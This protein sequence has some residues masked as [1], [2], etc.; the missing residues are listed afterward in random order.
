M[1]IPRHKHPAVPYVA[2]FAVFLLCLL[3]AGRT[4]IPQPWESVAWVG[5]VAVTI[6]L[7][8]RQL[9]AG[10]RLSSGVMSL[11]VGVGV[12][13][14]WVAPD[15][16][17][18]GWRESWVFQNSITGHVKISIAPAELSSPLVLWLRVVRAVVLVPILEELFWRGWLPRWIQDTKFERIPPGTF[19]AFAFIVTAVLFAA[20]HGPF[21]EVGLL[22]GLVYNWWMWRTK[23]LGDLVLAHAVTN[24]CLAGYVVLTQQ[25]QFWM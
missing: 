16:L 1:R 21:W 14:L 5:V 11:L 20:E 18:P 6:A 4:T 19:T 3:I 7:T 10:L 24:A 12:F 15:A 9:V 23:S 22:A 17:V 13:L 25:W 2:P 8:S